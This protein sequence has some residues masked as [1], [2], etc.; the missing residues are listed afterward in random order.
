MTRGQFLSHMKNIKYMQDNQSKWQAI[1][2]PLFTIKKDNFSRHGPA[3]EDPY[4]LDTEIHFVAWK[5]S[6]TLDETRYVANQM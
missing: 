4:G 1:S 5:A 6:Q 3:P 2:P